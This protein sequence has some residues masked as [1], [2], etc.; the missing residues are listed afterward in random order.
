MLRAPKTYNFA[1]YDDIVVHMKKIT[2]RLGADV[3]IDAAGAEADG[4][5]PEK[6]PGERSI[7]HKFLT[8]VFG[9]SCPPRAC[10]G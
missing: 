9:T 2:D 1:K 7:E 4:N 8:P 5:Q 3:A 6:W 10:P